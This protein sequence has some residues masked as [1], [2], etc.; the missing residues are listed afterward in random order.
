MRKVYLKYRN[1]VVAV[2]SSAVVG[3]TVIAGTAQAGAPSL[4]DSLEVTIEPGPV[5]AA[6]AAMIL[7]IGGIAAYKFVKSMLRG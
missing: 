6:M 7:I 4:A 1:K 2:V 5:Y 3:I